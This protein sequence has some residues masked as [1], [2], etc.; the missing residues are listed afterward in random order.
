[1][2]PFTIIF[3]LSLPPPYAFLLCWNSDFLGSYIFLFVYFL[4]SVEHILHKVH[5]LGAQFY[6]NILS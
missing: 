6:E 1:M 4:V 5:N 3:S 2:F